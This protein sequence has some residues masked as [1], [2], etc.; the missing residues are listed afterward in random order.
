VLAFGHCILAISSLKQLRCRAKLALEIENTVSSPHFMRVL[1]F[2]HCILAISSLKQLRCRAKLAL[3]IENT[4]PSP[5][6]I[7]V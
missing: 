1:A 2:G 7:L 4:V 5:H 6:F 3:E